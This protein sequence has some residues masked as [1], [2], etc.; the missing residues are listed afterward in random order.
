M[1]I[2][3]IDK[4]FWE[5]LYL[6][7][8]IAFNLLL[9][10]IN[11]LSYS[12]HRG[13]DFHIYGNYLDYFVFGQQKSLQEQT[14]GYFSLVSK[15]I[16]TNLNSLLISVDYKNLII[17]HGI[18]TTNYLLFIVG[19][20]GI[21]KILKYLNLDKFTSLTIINIL[22]IFPPLVGLR[23][24]LK[25]EILAFAFLP[26]IIY[27]IFLYQQNYS[28]K[29]LY[30]LFPLIGLLLSLKASVTL[31][32]G[33]AILLLLGKDS[34]KKEIIILGSFSLI[35]MFSLIIESYGY[36]NI[37]IWD[38]KTPPGYDFKAPFSFFYSI[39][40]D[41]WLNPYRDSQSSSMFGI[42]IL[43]TFGDYWERYWFHADGYLNNQ[44][45]ANKNLINMG[46]VLSTIFYLASL[47]YLVSEKNGKLRKL[48]LLGYLGL[49]VMMVNA[50]N[51][52]PFLTK[53]FNPSKGDPIKTHYFSFLLAF[54]FIYLMIKIFNK[55]NR[56]LT[57]LFF[58]IM[59][60]FS[61]QLLNPLSYEEIKSEQ[62]LINKIH[63]LSPCIL[64]DPV[65]RFIDYSHNWCTEQEIIKAFCFGEYN[66]DLIPV[67]KDD[68]LIFPVDESYKKINLVLNGNV[69]TVANYYE[70]LNYGEGG[71]IPQASEQYFVG[72]YPKPVHLFNTLFF[73][74]II[75]IFILQFR[76]RD[77]QN[78]KT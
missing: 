67:Q 53:N 71:F 69:V 51:L 32:V 27:S 8:T 10:V 1:I 39:N 20:F 23:M 40:S 37:Y 36:T 77:E 25:P 33:L 68:Y 13:T 54:T 17:N 55:R 16:S 26:W 38:H 64:G 74:S 28:R 19:L 5:K 22:T 18:Q 45:P 42:L 31:M 70:C 58:S 6:V 57:L 66:E 9:F 56:I 63:F 15:V 41:V 59:A 49:F 78:K 4:F 3:K 11:Y 73:L 75:S 60:I 24:I 65:S 52:I 47:I 50:F 72:N 30:I 21:Y 76:S 29:Y 62:N 34:F 43:D 35:A 61:F 12:S 48:G 44:Y 46:S 7:F 2:M 14:V